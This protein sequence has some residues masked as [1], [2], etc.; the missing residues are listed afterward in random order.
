MNIFKKVRKKS[1]KE[2]VHKKKTNSKIKRVT[3]KTS[4][5]LGNIKM[6]PK[7]MSGF[8]IIAILCAGMGIYASLGLADVSD[9]SNK[10]YANIL[11]PTKKAADI[12]HSF[13][14]ECITLRQVLLDDSESMLPAYISKLNNKLAAISDLS[15][16][17][18]LISEDKRNDLNA[19][20][21]AVAVYQPLLENAIGNIQNGNKQAIIE[22]LSHFGELKNAETEVERA[23]DTFVY[24]ISSDASAIAYNNEKRSDTILSVTISTISVVLLLS[25]LLGIV[26]SR[27]ISRPIKKLTA[28]VRLLAAGE[29]DIAIDDKSTKDEVGQMKEA[30]KTI[31]QAIKDLE[32]DTDRLI[33]AAM[34]GQLSVR[35]DTKKHQGTYRKILEGFNATLVATISPI[36][37]SAVIL[38]ELSK[39]NLN[40]SV[41]GDFKGDFAI[42]KDALNGT[43]ETIKGYIS[44]IA[45]ILGEIANGVLTQ[46]I[47]SEYKG[48]FAVLKDSINKSIDSFNSVLAD[49]DDAAEEVAAGT[50]QVSSSS[51]TIS[52]GSTEQ[53]SALEELTVSISDIAEQ[54]KRNAE[55]AD[56]A[57]KLSLKAKND[58]LSGNEK[59]K[60]LQNAMQDINES[61][62]NISKIIKVID[63]IA[64]QTNILS[65]NAAVEAAH[66]G[67]HGRGFAVVADE[68]R[69]LAARSAKAAQETTDIIDRSIIKTKAGTKIADET[70]D[71]LLNVVTGVQ[72]TVTLSGEIAVAS[73][74]QATGIEQ[75]NTGIAQLSLVVQNNSATSEEVAASSE[76][77]SMQADN[78]K[79]MVRKFT[80]A[81]DENQEE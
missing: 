66:A 64:F 7:I 37:E 81:S 22:D 30:F 4:T 9:S 68:V 44:E 27:G 36:N 15:M 12:S 59:M 60:S 71:A 14:E 52:Q 45:Y 39:G 3:K 72:K 6:A 62:A 49:I 48:D 10:M 35:A 26:M 13:Q 41:T 40:V 43:I 17:E 74:A 54:T 57:N 8:L 55:N 19:L 77:L 16:V 2:K 5:I 11:L 56:E 69:N 78:L 28:D 67:V 24:S 33:G 34:E 58:A 65:L 51:Q 63:D 31:L 25:I 53:T 42:V 80:L 61:S 70:A 79:E 50:A 76:E 73:N 75:V 1:K 46:S 18:L 29:T 20:K 38:G 23:I 32:Y 47:Q 21:S